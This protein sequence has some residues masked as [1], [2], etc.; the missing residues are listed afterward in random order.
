MKIS[1]QVIRHEFT[2]QVLVFRSEITIQVW[3]LHRPQK[4]PWPI[5]I[6]NHPTLSH[7]HSPFLFPPSL[8][9][10]PQGR[11][12]LSPRLLAFYSN[13]FGIKT[14]FTLLWEDIEDI[15]ENAPTIPAIN[16]LIN[17]SLTL[18]LKKGKGGDARAA[19]Y[20]VDPSGRLKFR[21]MSF[22]RPKVAFRY[23]RFIHLL[24]VLT[25]P[26]PSPYFVYVFFQVVSA[27][28][29]QHMI[30]TILLPLSHSL[31]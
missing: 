21:I 14:R 17:P 23:G 24:S 11:V 12:F 3:M 6:H 9:F 20:A 31:S 2:T 5:R 4:S 19:S 27:F 22:V 15:R 10:L 29:F 26:S 7:L 13:L 25:R 30:I 8:L 18:F 1:I 16:R 28:F